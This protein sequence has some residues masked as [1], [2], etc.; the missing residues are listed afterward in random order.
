MAREEIITGL[1]NALER[2]QPIERA[3]QSLITAGYNATEVNQVAREMNTSILHHLPEQEQ[4]IQEQPEQIKTMPLQ[5]KQ[6]IKKE[7][8]Q[9]QA[10][11]NLQTQNN[12]GFLDDSK[13]KKKMPKA[14]WILIILL[15]I[16]LIGTTSF[17]FFGKEILDMFFPKV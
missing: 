10:N 13:P 3:I 15:I 16:I 9:V 17:I 11:Q 12:T 14:L 7:N 2:G 8:Q 1:R 6:E 4:E 5:Q